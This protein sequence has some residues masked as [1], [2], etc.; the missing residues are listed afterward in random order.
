MYF[1]DFSKNISDLENEEPII[2]CRKQI[3]LDELAL[4]GW[5]IIFDYKF[6]GDGGN[7]SSPNLNNKQNIKIFSNF[8]LSPFFLESEI[9]IT[10]KKIN[11]LIDNILVYFFKYDKKLINNFE[12][13]INLKFKNLNN[14]FIKN[15]N[16]NFLISEK[17]VELSK[18]FFEFMNFGKLNSEIEFIE[19]I[20]E[21]NFFSKNELEIHN[22][23]ELSKFLQ[24]NQKKIEGIEKAYFD[25]VKSIY[26]NEYYINLYLH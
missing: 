17:K 26:S 11:F 12:G 9:L 22:N 2:E 6:F 21:L 20:G 5:D 8:Q 1:H 14:Q 10:N 25:I 23:K 4:P 13:K 18:S 7:I 15:G 16:I 24:I 3:P 19:E